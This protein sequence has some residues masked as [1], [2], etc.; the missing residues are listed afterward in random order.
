[1]YCACNVNISIVL[2]STSLRT[3]SVTSPPAIRINYLEASISPAYILIMTRK[4]SLV[5]TQRG[6]ALKPAQAKTKQK[7][8]LSKTKC[9]EKKKKLGRR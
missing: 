5:R 2:G 4:R 1:M 8:I 7:S 3:M 9:R 6:A